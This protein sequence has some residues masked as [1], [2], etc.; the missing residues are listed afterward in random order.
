MDRISKFA[1]A[2]LA[3]PIS[4]A[5]TVAIAVTFWL[6]WRSKS[7]GGELYRS[8]PALLTTLGVLGTFFGIFWG[9]L[10]FDENNIDDSVPKLLEGLKVA[11]WSSVAGMAAALV[12]RFRQARETIAATDAAEVTPE[13]INDT[14]KS[15]REAVENASAR[16]GTA[17]EDLRKAISA[18][19]DSSLL[20]QI[21]KLRTDFADGQKDLLRAFREFAET[22]A[23]NNSKA[24]IAALEQV[25]RDFNTKLNEQFGEN[26]KQL[27]EAVGALL[28]WQEN[29]RKHVEQL[30]LRFEEALQGIEA[31]EQALRKIARHTERIP[32][33]LAGMEKILEGLTE[34]TKNL[35]GHL[36]AVSG[37][38]DR[39]LDAFPVI[40]KNLEMLTD[41]FSRSV[42]QAVE[43]SQQ[44]LDQQREAHQELHRGFESLLENSNQ[45][46]ERFTDAL[47][48]T[49]QS[50]QA[51]IT[52]QWKQALERQR[53]AHEELH[54]GFE[55]LLENSN[56]SQERFANALSASLQSVQSSIAEI[57]RKTEQEIN[58]GFDRF[59]NQM[60]GEL[61]RTIE[62]MGKHLASLSEK[63]VADY[64]PLTEQLRR[65]VQI[66]NGVQRK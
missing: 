42:Q 51:A 60:Q 20:T 58:A 59:E 4:L 64:G 43:Q 35:N 14:L 63:F 32:E 19:S 18:D 13:V 41:K 12:L 47:N 46:Q 52:E 31:S 39:A 65:I 37:L 33:T 17:L 21:Q 57:G 24:L 5:F 48:A 66:A 23:E 56:R 50:L 61:H 15:I 40:E 25:I 7:N 44:S 8:G 45:S 27:N 54:R 1:E 3:E 9:L 29:Y 6:A 53:E 16:Q 36:E 34:A 11:F 28:I 49:L 2:V 22:M 10:D 55:A 62:A 30:E 38:R 26:F